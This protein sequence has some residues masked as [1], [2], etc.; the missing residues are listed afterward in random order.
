M[1]CSLGLPEG[2]IFSCL[3]VWMRPMKIPRVNRTIGHP[4]ALQDVVFFC[5]FR[6]V[7]T[8]DSMN[9]NP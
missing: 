2:I 6:G 1:A 7:F 3:F 8:Q 4:A 9:K 5:S